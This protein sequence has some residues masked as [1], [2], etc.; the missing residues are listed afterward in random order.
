LSQRFQPCGFRSGAAPAAVVLPR[1]IKLFDRFS[2][3]C[4]RHFPDRAVTTELDNVPVWGI[5]ILQHKDEFV[6]RLTST[7]FTGVDDRDGVD[8]PISP[9]HRALA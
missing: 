4:N 2:A 1:R 5:A 3:S 6:L 9:E 7:T 8:V